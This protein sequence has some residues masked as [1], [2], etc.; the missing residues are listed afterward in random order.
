MLLWKAQVKSQYNRYNIDMSLNVKKRNKGFTLVELM[1][2]VS[3]FIIIMV[4]SMG[5]ILTIIDANR[6]SQ[7]LRSVMDNLNFTLE[8][9]TRT[10]RFGTNYHCG[11]TPPALSSPSDCAGGQ[12]SFTVLSSD[13]VTQVTYKLSG[14]R[15]ARSIN[16]GTDFFLTSSDVYIDKL[17]FY[18]L[19][20]T[21]YSGGSNLLQPRTIIVIMGHVGVNG[22]TSK[23][24]FTI[25]TTIS[26]RQFDTQ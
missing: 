21:L 17:T 23:S 20:S 5:S 16:S 24:S 19:G 11:G 12:D 15:I 25:Q 9:M 10:I 6:K 1:V 26:Q 22:S 8:A 4:I 13:G 2:S 7:N 3:I 14:T 18:T